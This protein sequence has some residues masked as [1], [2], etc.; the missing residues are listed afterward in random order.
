M[1]PI[2]IPMQ[3]AFFE[4]QSDDFHGYVLFCSGDANFQVGTG[5]RLKIEQN[6]ASDGGAI[7][8]IQG[9]RVSIEQQDCSWYAALVVWYC[10]SSILQDHDIPQKSILSAETLSDY[11]SESS[12]RGNGQCNLECMN[13]ACNWDDGGS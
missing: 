6:S 12:L 3:N 8:L 5:H 2:L 9:G 4:E 11:H 1:L 7:A 10:V 13:V